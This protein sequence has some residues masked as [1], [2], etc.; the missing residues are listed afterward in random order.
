[1]TCTPLALASVVFGSLVDTC[2]GG[3]SCC[4]APVNV[5]W[6]VLT[7]CFFQARFWWRLSVAALLAGTPPPVCGL[8]PCRGPD[9]RV[10]AALRFC[11]AVSPRV[12]RSF[13][14][15]VTATLLGRRGQVPGSLPQ[16]DCGAP[17][18]H[19]P[20]AG[21]W[22]CSL[23]PRQMVVI[24]RSQVPG[25]VFG[26]TLLARS[27]NV[28]HCWCRCWV[29]SSEHMAAQTPTPCGSTLGPFQVSLLNALDLLSNILWPVEVDRLRK[30]LAPPPLLLGHWKPL[31]IN[32]PW[33]LL[34]K[35]ATR[36][37]VQKTRE[38]S[39]TVGGGCGCKAAQRTRTVPGHG[40]VCFVS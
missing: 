35:K 22:P 31:M 13:V 9:P 4:F 33:S 17:P 25:L 2:S 10:S 38:T 20:C 16:A 5:V 26:P 39:S 28:G 24:L 19:V 29:F 27:L 15:V 7:L 8:P 21:L 32:L 30:V 40:T 12:L 6:T 1:M 23:P 18:A 11:C 37:K 36:R 34:Q 14:L 3:C